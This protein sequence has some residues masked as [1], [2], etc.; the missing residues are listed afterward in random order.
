M[1][2]QSLDHLD[3]MDEI[4]ICWEAVSDMMNPDGGAI[5]EHERDHIAVLL[6]LLQREYFVAL[7]ALSESIQAEVN[8]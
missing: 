6:N 4:G 7:K 3:R 8:D 5:Q 2:K 1:N